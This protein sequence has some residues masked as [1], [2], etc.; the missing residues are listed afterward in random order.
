MKKISQE[1][2]EAAQH[3][4]DAENAVIRHPDT[5]TAKAHIILAAMAN[6]E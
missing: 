3:W 1:L 6:H 4:V 2:I 5:D